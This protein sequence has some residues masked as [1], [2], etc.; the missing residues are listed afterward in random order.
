MKP[1]KLS[2]LERCRSYRDRLIANP[3]VQRWA[4]ANPL[5]RPV[6]RRQ[7][8]AALDLCAGFVYS[9]VLFTCVRLRLLEILFDEPLTAV[10]LSER[11]SLSPEATCRLLDAAV[12]LGLAERRGRFH[13]GLGRLGAALVGS[14]AALAVIE[15]Q[16]LLYADLQDPVA[17]LQGSPRSDGI[18]RYWPYSA[19]AH[20]TALTA[21]EVAPY[22]ALM[23]ASQPL[24][25][26]EVLDTYPIHRHRCLLDVGGG[27]GVFLAAAAARAPDLR[28]ML[29]D[30]PAVADR[31][32]AR[33][34]N[35]GLLERTSI[36]H[37]DFLKDALPNGADVISLIRI[38]H[39]HDDASALSLL[40]AA[41]RAL[42]ADGT[43]LI[44]E[45]MCGV[46]GAES[47]DAYY[48]FYMLA[49]GRGQ[50]RTVDEIGKLLRQAGFGRFRL[51]HNRMPV[52]AR[53]LVAWPTSSC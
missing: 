8:R 48:E 5:T 16:P 20:P 30:L 44:A 46:P 9:Q 7:A 35:A 32:R 13:Y 50:P 28:L 15:H 49:M 29:L 38:V 27:E 24:I 19:A 6:L 14:R 12:S 41:R 39:D 26:G 36:Y 10:G 22:S 33:I 23:A 2:W 11:L 17:L 34:A 21:E 1:E 53:I 47:L 52:L 4:L 25:A 31:A 51:L 40:R 37:G 42:P 45:A 43:L 3:R 18:A